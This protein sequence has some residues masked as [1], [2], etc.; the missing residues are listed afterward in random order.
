MKLL[1]GLLRFMKIMFLLV[2]T[3][4]IALLGLGLLLEVIVPWF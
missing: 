3:V 4:V 2:I 1:D